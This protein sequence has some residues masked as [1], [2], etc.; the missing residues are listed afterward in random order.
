MLAVTVSRGD[1]V[2]K[3][4][5]AKKL[6][7]TYEVMSIL[8]AIFFSLIFVFNDQTTLRIVENSPSAIRASGRTSHAVAKVFDGYRTL[9]TE[10]K[11]LG[12]FANAEFPKTFT[13]SSFGV[14][15]GEDNLRERFGCCGLL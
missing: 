6:H 5:V 12:Y 14:G 4:N 10:L 15:L 2:A 1:S 13:R 8:L 9:F 3:S 7:Q 11:E